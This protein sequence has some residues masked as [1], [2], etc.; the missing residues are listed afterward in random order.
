MADL[1]LMMGI[2]GSGKSTLAKKI[3]ES[4]DIYIS[5]DEIRFNLLDINNTNEYFSME[6]EVYQ[7]FI[8]QINI[9]L[10][11]NYRYV[12]ADA[13]H[14]NRGSRRK[15]LNKIKSNPDHIYVIYVD[16]PIKIALQRN[17]TRDGR[18]KVP[19]KSI[20][21]MWNSIQFP[22]AD[23]GIDTVFIANEEGYIDIN[24]TVVLKGDD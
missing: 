9:A 4:K 18:A 2:P 10:T 17:A 15:L 5:R 23:E 20:W 14:L 19:E 1:I 3:C 24:K 7:N 16:V 22:Q 12:Y 6:K 8:D 21:N 11:K 13:T